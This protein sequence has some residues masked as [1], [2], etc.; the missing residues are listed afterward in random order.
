MADDVVEI[1]V[2]PG[3]TR[4]DAGS[5]QWHREREDLREALQRALGGGAIRE[6]EPAPGEKGLALAPIIARLTGASAFQALALAFD[7][8]LQH[9]SG[10]RT[11]EITGTV[12]GRDIALN[13]RAGNASVNALEPLMQ[14]MGQA[15]GQGL[16]DGVK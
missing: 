16:S 9:R 7:S 12:N 4:F 13:I 14:A 1:L 3:S 6:G 10:D 8:W 5:E 11:L 15:M 2:E